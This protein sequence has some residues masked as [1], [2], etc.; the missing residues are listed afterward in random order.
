[1]AAGLLCPRATP[2]LLTPRNPWGS[3]I[4]YLSHL[5]FGKSESCRRDGLLVS[6]PVLFS[7]K[8]YPGNC[9][10]WQTRNFITSFILP[11]DIVTWV[12]ASKPMGGK[13]LIRQKEGISLAFC[14]QGGTWVPFYARHKFLID[15]QW[16]NRL[17]RKRAASRR[18]KVIQI[19]CLI[20]AY[21]MLPRTTSNQTILSDRFS[22]WS[23]QI[24]I[25]FIDSNQIS[26]FR[27]QN[28]KIHYTQL[29]SVLF[30]DSKV[31]ITLPCPIRPEALTEPSLPLNSV[32]GGHLSTPL[33]GL[34]RNLYLHVL[35]KI[36]PSVK[37]AD[38]KWLRESPSQQAPHI[39]C[40]VF[41]FLCQ[42]ITHLQPTVHQQ[43]H[44]NR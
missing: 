21:S 34:K 40:F 41:F 6:L 32:E 16:Q 25:S 7:L 29:S 31:Y 15:W 10:K 37:M 35:T 11:S 9:F 36:I 2:S 39:D 5:L 43:S 24:C 17:K 1:M 23:M 8:F 18:S 22:L 13:Q 19:L 28:S 20:L 12:P 3:G 30:S 38:L 14:I 33:A 4:W 44:H 27:H 42:K 26:L